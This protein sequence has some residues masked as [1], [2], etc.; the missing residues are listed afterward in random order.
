MRPSLRVENTQSD[1][2]KKLLAFEKE[3]NDLRAFEKEP[4]LSESQSDLTSELPS[5]LAVEYDDSFYHPTAGTLVREFK[6]QAPFFDAQTRWAEVFFALVCASKKGAA[7][8]FPKSAKSPTTSGSTSFPEC[9]R[10]TTSC[11]MNTSFL[12]TFFRRAY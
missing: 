9:Y 1:L 10:P 3:L 4:E 2:A 11:R 7:S 6:E 12:S 8:A 5:E